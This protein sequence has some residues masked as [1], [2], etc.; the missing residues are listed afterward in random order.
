V[1]A[2]RATAAKSWLANV[3]LPAQ[4]RPALPRLMEASS[5]GRD[6]T[7]AAVRAVIAA[8]AP[9]LDKAARL[10]LDQLAAA[11]EGR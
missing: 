2:E 4:V 10:E 5:A 3:T 7:A 8:A 9:Q 1:R 11:L 6:A